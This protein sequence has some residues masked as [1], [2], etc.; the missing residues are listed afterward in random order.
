MNA[1]AFVAS[2]RRLLIPNVLVDRL[3]RGFPSMVLPAVSTL[4]LSLEKLLVSYV[5]SGTRR[6][7]QLKTI[8]VFFFCLSALSVDHEVLQLQSQSNSSEGHVSI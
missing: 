2:H 3:K 8:Y 6:M 1:V 7:A 5:F 4:S